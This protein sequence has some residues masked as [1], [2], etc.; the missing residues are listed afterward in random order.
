[1]YR[2]D[3][4]EQLKLGTAAPPSHHQVTGV[5]PT[6]WRLGYTSLLTDVSAE[7]VNSILPVY[8]VLHLHMSP[9]QYGA[10]DGV[11][12]GMAL[13]LLALVG[14]LLA[15]RTRRYKEVAAFGYGMSAACKLLLLVGGAAWGWITAVVAIDRAG[16]GARTAP[17]DA[18][19]SLVTG[20]GS[21][22][23]AF[24]VHRALD[25][26]GS[27]LGPV[28]AF[29]LLTLLPD[30]FDAIWMTSFVFALIGLAVLWLF[31]QNPHDARAP[32]REPSGRASLRA[33]W[34]TLVLDAVADR[35]LLVLIG[36]GVLLALATMSDGFVYLMLQ[37]RSHIA[38]SYFPLFYLATACW[39]MVLSIP[40]GRIADRWGR[41]P[42]LLAGYG[43]VAAIYLILIV[44][45]EASFTGSMFCLFLFGLHYAATEGVL[46]AMA[47]HL[48]PPECRTTGLA[49]VA[50]CI[51]FAKMGSSL[52][53]GLV[54]QM[55]GAQ[56]ALSAFA[57][58]LATAVLIALGLLGA[59]A[60]R[61]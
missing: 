16:K 7:M 10:I 51:G 17:R 3:W 45:P 30:A 9:L 34:R 2:L 47:S 31:V 41:T 5:S 33:V 40:A 44:A 19:I 43:A 42:V 36:A 59:H 4:V 27:L 29:G 35:R 56:I 1:M 13:A 55:W 46:T 37:E 24:A 26:G 12:N 57:V 49:I 39:Y 38:S 11:Y 61:A 15:D 53:F 28:V 21:L 22:A 23:S 60:E 14:G 18:M 50:S 58:G 52:L 20:G 8:I 54:W 48:I 25:A 6:V 32:A